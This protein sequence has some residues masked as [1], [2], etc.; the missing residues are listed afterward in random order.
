M[1]TLERI[2]ENLKVHVVM[3]LR[4]PMDKIHIYIQLLLNSHK[5]PPICIRLCKCAWPF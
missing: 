4:K 1:Q 5:L 2:W 3:Y